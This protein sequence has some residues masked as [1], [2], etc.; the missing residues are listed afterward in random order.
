MSVAE[1]TARYAHG[2]LPQ[3]KVLY[4]KVIAENGAG[5]SGD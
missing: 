5:A 3:D 4:F 2:S 1:E